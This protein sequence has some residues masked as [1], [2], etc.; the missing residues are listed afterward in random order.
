MAKPIQQINEYRTTEFAEY[1]AKLREI[2]PINTNEKAALYRKIYK[3]YHDKL[4]NN[5]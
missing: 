4:K 2:R 5:S 3:E 1:R